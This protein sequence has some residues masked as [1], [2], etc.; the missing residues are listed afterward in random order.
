MAKNIILTF[1][2]TLTLTFDL[3]CQKFID[4]SICYSIY[5]TSCKSARQIEEV[6]A[7]N[8]ILTIYVTLTLTFDPGC[9]HFI[10]LP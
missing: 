6:M 9:Q 10:C 2:V 8:F 7:K 4:I 1:Y 3:G 5:E